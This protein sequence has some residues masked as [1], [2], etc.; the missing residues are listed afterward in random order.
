MV[1]IELATA[2]L[3]LAAA[4]AS[5]GTARIL[6]ELGDAAQPSVIENPA[7]GLL[8]SWQARLE[9]GCAALHVAP[10]TADGE[11][12]AVRE[13]ARGCDWFINWA[14]FPSF[15]VADNG[16]WQGFFLR[17]QGEG[18]YAYHVYQTR[19]TDG[20]RNWSQP[21]RLHDDQSPSEHGFVAF[22]PAGGDRIL[23]VWLDGRQGADPESH[24]HNAHTDHGDHGAMSL[25]SA[26]IGRD[27]VIG[28]EQEVD[29]RVCSC[30]PNSLVR[31][32]GQHLAMYRN[33]SPT[34]IR[35]LGLAHFADERWQQRGVV[36]DDGYYTRGCPVNGGALAVRGR[37]VLA[38][39]PTL[40]EGA[41]A[42]RIRTLDE[43]GSADGPMHELESEKSTLG[44]VSAASLSDSWL[45]SWL[46]AGSKAGL[47]T[48]KLARLNT[49]LAVIALQPVVDLPAGRDLGMPR[50]ASNGDVATLVY[51]VAQS[52][53]RRPDGRVSTRLAV[54]Q[55]RFAPLVTRSATLAD[56]ND[57]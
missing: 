54:F 34:E 6:D 8:L 47:T 29:D 24:D 15:A 16:D 5:P 53:E 45:I 28:I 46:G 4:A 21:L 22:A 2:L 9:D 14:D 27:G 10:L 1:R 23:A 52:G 13:V 18:R 50:L 32:A 40:V 56:P 11:L 19:S 38:V 44:R 17:R 55:E 41:I 20:G 43:R 36:H 31:V 42:V 3:G 51:T 39:W 33:R 35:D 26:V 37:Q 25:R 48:L 12:G 30:C 57:P 49:D 7:G